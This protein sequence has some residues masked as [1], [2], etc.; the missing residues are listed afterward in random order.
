MLSQLVF[1]NEG[2]LRK[3]ISI[4]IGHYRHRRYYQRI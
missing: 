2:D 3:T 4:F 1:L